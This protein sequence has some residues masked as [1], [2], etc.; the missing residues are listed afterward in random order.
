M[1]LVLI[2]I[3]CFWPKRTKGDNNELDRKLGETFLLVWDDHS[4]KWTVVKPRTHRRHKNMV[5]IHLVWCTVISN[6]PTGLDYSI[7]VYLLCNRPVDTSQSIA[8]FP[9][10]TGL[11]FSAEFNPLHDVNQ[12]LHI[13]LK[14]ARQ[15]ER[16]PSSLERQYSIYCLVHWSSASVL[17]FLAKFDVGLWKEECLC[18]ISKPINCY[19]HIAVGS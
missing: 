17:G 2:G 6:Y 19:Y 15:T 1:Y 3:L 5:V 10:P 11:L 13:R 9:C 12:L 18:K 8:N 4:T 16:I 14:L 7:S